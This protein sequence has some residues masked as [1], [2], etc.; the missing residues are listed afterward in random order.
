MKACCVALLLLFALSASG[1]GLEVDYACYQGDDSLALCE[2][3]VGVQRDAL[4]YEGLEDA[5]SLTA[6]FSVVLS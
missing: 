4:F 1:A 3:Y 2:V 5:D 6:A